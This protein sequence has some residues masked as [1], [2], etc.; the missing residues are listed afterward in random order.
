[1]T[2]VEQA[3]VGLPSTRRCVSRRSFSIRVKAPRGVKLT[4]AT[5]FVD[6]RKVAVRRGVKL[7]APVN[8]KGL[9]KGRYSVKIVL[10]LASGKQVTGTRRY[11]TCTPKKS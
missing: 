4:S 2:A 3:I 9:P 1:M 5:V 11:R 10:K 7:T 6:A 8:L